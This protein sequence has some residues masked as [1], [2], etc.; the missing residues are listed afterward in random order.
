[1][2]ETV[3]LNIP[4]IFWWSSSSISLSVASRSCRCAPWQKLQDDS[5]LETMKSPC[6]HK[7]R[8]LL[9]FSAI[10]INAFVSSYRPPL[11]FVVHHNVSKRRRAVHLPPQVDCKHASSRAKSLHMSRLSRECTEE[12][13]SV[14]VQKGSDLTTS[15]NEDKSTPISNERTL[16][17]L[18]LLTVPLAWGTY[19]PVVKYMYDRMDPS[20]PGFIFS[21]G[22]YLVAAG[23][24]SAL[25]WW[26]IRDGASDVDNNSYSIE[27]ES[28]TLGGLEL[29][30][31]LFLGNG[32]QV[33]G[34][35][36][37]PA[38][39]AAFLVQLTTVMVPLVSAWVSG[40]GLAS[41][42]LMTWVAC[43]VAF[44]GVIIMGM[45]DNGQ[46]IQIFTSDQLQ[47]DAIISSVQIS[48]GDGLIVLAALA[49]TMHVVRLGV[50]AP[51]S[52]PLTLAASKARTEAMFSVILVMAL[53]SVAEINSSSVPLFFRQLGGEI[54][55]YF[56]TIQTMVYKT[57]G[58][59]SSQMIEPS[60]V[61]IFIA[62]ILWT[63]MIT[64]AYTIYAQSFGQQR[65]NPVDSNLIY[66][67]QP[68]FS[69]LFAYGLLGEK[70]GLSGW[71]G[72][73]LIGIALGLVAFGFEEE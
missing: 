43:I 28:P 5:V 59:T 47:W 69:S 58:A 44:I 10:A 14:S 35:Q 52:R 51:N 8:M 56:E 73:L 7:R 37:V 65:I 32:F 17:I 36:T 68:L 34:L 42:P 48:Y 39:R 49:Y 11:S 3:H 55:N 60:S 15:T 66:T 57:D 12:D 25:N 33:V 53:V 20:V 30:S 72:A 31:Y 2:E 24:L 70:L 54:V 63:G 27:E 4:A 22:Y 62:A 9:W 64:S 29:G 21:A 45:D 19:T 38:D 23:V 46:S 16:G 1:M 6:R 50:Y 41:V 13:P 40:R 71:I 67:T 61:L 26:N 18:I